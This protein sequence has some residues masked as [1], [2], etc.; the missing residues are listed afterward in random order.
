MNTLQNPKYIH[1]GVF[2]LGISYTIYFF[3]QYLFAPICFVLAK[4]SPSLDSI[5]GVFEIFA[6]NQIELFTY[7]SFIISVASLVAFLIGFY[8]FNNKQRLL[9]VMWLKKEWS[10]K[11]AEKIFWILLV[12]GF[13]FKTLRLVEGASVEQIVNEHIKHGYI[14]TPYFT[15]YFSFNWFHLIALAVIN[16][17]YQEAKYK[18]DPLTDRL[19]IQAIS[20]TVLYIGITF[21]TGSKTATI[22]PL[23]CYLIINKYYAGINTSLIKTIFQMALIVLIVFILKI[24]IAGWTDAIGYDVSG[25]YAATT[26]YLLFNRVNLSYV[27]AAVIDKAP[28]LYP[29]GTLAQFWVEMGLYGS[30]HK[31]IL[32]GNELGRTIGVIP[33]TDHITGMAI[34]NIGE[35]YINFNLWGLLIGMFI[36]GL[37]Y[38]IFYSSCQTR[39]PLAVMVYALMWPILIHGMESPIGVLYATSIKMIALCLFVHLLMTFRIKFA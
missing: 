7:R 25:G 38:K 28:S 20:Y 23:L 10:L 6:T 15:Y 37:L 30:E 19:K 11:R 14:S 8:S 18:G 31:N 22:F 5:N 16:V 34:T 33:E 26:L 2:S 27:L 35:L 4:N 12:T 24:A 3:M 39:T 17:I 29:D 21:S 32:D 1:L 13:L 9:N 36:T